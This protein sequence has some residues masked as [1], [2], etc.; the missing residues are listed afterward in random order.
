MIFVNE[1]GL[2]FFINELDNH[3]KLKWVLCSFL[4]RID[5]RLLSSFADYDVDED[6][7]ISFLKQ[8][9]KLMKDATKGVK[10]K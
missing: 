5:K 10:N 2:I 6:Y 1:I 7:I 9:K 8:R 3:L 4:C